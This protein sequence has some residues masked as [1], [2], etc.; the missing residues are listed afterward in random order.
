MK[1][2]DVIVVGDANP[3]LI[4]TGF[5]R[6]PA[7]GQEIFTKGLFL[8]IGGCRLMC[9]GSGKAWVEGTVD[10]CCR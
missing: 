9:C 8:N 2:F 10:C 1:K 4:F 6:L 5:D 3:D 7:M